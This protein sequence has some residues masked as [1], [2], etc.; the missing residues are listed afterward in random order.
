MKTDLAASILARLRNVA[1]QRGEDPQLVLVRF[2]NERLLY[3][4]SI[5]DVASD[6]VLKGAT[7]FLVWEGRS[8]RV[9]RDLDLLGVGTPDETRMVDVFRHVCAVRCDDDAVEF[10]PSGVRASAIREGAAYAGIRVRLRARLGR[11]DVPVQID[12][13]FGD[14]VTPSPEW[15]EVPPLL[16]LPVARVRGYPR[17]TVV[18]EKVDAMVVLGRDNSRMKDFHDVWLLVREPVDDELLGRAL[19]VTFDRRRTSLPSAVP[20]ALTSAFAE[21]PVKQAQWRA[22]LDRARVE[23][24]PPLDQVVADLHRRLW[25]LLEARPG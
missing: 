20:D 3:R 25:S 2:V 12:I 22:F 23:Q 21:D 16:E 24:R 13:G 7:M 10:D 14:A 5:S 1:R 18:A 4:L 17:E 9:T 15:V 19:R 6:F 11:A 8:H